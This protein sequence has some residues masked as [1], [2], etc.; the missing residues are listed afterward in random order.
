MTT[1]YGY[2]INRVTGDN[3]HKVGYKSKEKAQNDAK[4]QFLRDNRNFHVT[5]FEYES[6]NE[7]YTIICNRENKGSK[8]TA[9]GGTCKVSSA[10]GRIVRYIE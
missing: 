10:K 7:D 1:E 8:V 4:R 9:H 3:I 2:D 6:D 5:V